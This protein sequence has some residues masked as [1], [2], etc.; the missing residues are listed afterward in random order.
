MKAKYLLFALC[1]FA[2]QA[3]AQRI[4]SSCTASNSVKII[5]QN[6]ADQMALRRINE[7]K[8]PAQ[9]SINIPFPHTD[10]ILKVLLAVY[11]LKTAEADT[12]ARIL[13]LHT[14]PK[15]DLNTCMVFADSTAA[16]MLK[17]RNKITPCGQ[18]TIDALMSTYKLK[19]SYSTS[20][21]NA[22]HVIIFR[23]DINLNMSKLA[24]NLRPIFGVNMV[25]SNLYAGD[26]DDITAKW[27]DNYIQLIYR[28]AWGDCPSGCSFAHFWKFNIYPDC[29]VEFI[30]SYGDKLPNTSIEFENKPSIALQPNPFSNNFTITNTQG[31]VHIR[32]INMQSALVYDSYTES[33]ELNDLG[34]LAP[35]FYYVQIL[36][37]DKSTWIKAIKN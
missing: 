26:G 29:S 7:N 20:S 13:K 18:S 17:L 22:S 14:F 33:N 1:C 4:Q 9:D 31:P 36:E 10:S 3:R 15:Y 25:F 12:V 19:Y 11:N 32:I 34:D 2:M 37:A 16:W 35:G 5:Y 30:R 28:Y 6:D 27:Y 8:F 23:S 21:L 24:E